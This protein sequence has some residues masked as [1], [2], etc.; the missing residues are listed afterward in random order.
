MKAPYMKRLSLILMLISITIYAQEKKPN[1]LFIFADDMSYEAIG[2][3]SSEVK[4]PHL[5]KLMSRGANFSHTYNMGGWNGAICMAS[6]AMLNCGSHINFA[7]ENIKTK[8]RWSEL[9]KQAGYKTYMTGKWHVPGKPR[10][11][12]VRDVR[13]GMPKGSGYNRPKNEKDYKSGWKPWDKSF[14]GFWAGGKHWSEIVADHGIDYMKMAQKDDKPFF[15]YL[16]FNAPHDPRQ[17]PKEYV[18]MY[19]LDKIKVP[20]NYLSVY[21][22]HKEIGCSPKL[23]DERLAPFPRSKFA[24]QIHRQEYYAIITHMDAQ[25]GR[26]LKSLEESGKADNTYIVFT[27]DHGLS[28][29]HHGLIGKQNMYDHSMRVPFFIAGPGVKAGQTIKQPIYLQDVMP[30]ALDVAGVDKPE[31]VHFQSLLPIIKGEKKTNVKAVF[32]K[33]INFQRMVIKDNYK[34]IY[35]PNTEIKFRLF[36]LKKDPH[37]MDDLAKNPEYKAVL[38]KMKAEYISLAK[39]MNDKID[40]F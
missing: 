17:A 4:T 2:A 36:N 11:D 18:D 40:K 26:I 20:K 38:E 35:Y 39:S 32:G 10:F 33:Y 21:P 27:A 8:P 30:T 16:A 15:M 22:Y 29:G 6:R 14:G 37:E 28:V 34:L 12:V 19:P 23:R 1:F 3:L 13:G 24:V 7:Q 9:M 31:H 5:D 25:I